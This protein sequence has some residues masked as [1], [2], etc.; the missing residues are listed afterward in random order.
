MI[1][2][3]FIR[4]GIE[5]GLRKLVDNGNMSSTNIKRVM[6]IVTDVTSTLKVELP[7]HDDTPVR[8][9]PNKFWIVWCE[10][11]TNVKY[12]HHTYQQAR[13]EAERLAKKHPGHKFYVM[14]AAASAQTTGIMC[15]E[16]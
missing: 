1:D 9:N 14:A 6:D 15:E 12:K 13:L 4:S 2:V 8:I 7:V 11:T 5:R 3:F 10:N 16:Y